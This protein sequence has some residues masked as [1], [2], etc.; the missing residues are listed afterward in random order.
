MARSTESILRTS[1][2]TPYAQSDPPYPGGYYRFN[3]SVCDGMIPPQGGAISVADMRYR[4][5]WGRS[6]FNG[7][8]AMSGQPSGAIYASSFRNSIIFRVWK[9]E[10][11]KNH[12]SAQYTDPRGAEIDY[13]MMSGAG[14]ASWNCLQMSTGMANA[15]ISQG[16]QYIQD[17]GPNGDAWG[18]VRRID[19]ANVKN[20]D[21]QWWDFCMRWGTYYIRVYK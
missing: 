21:W 5:F 11:W 12:R 19:S 14:G 16:F 20:G 18:G 7:Y 4:D 17:M 15:L 13:C 2:I 1:G 6:D 3:R 9:E 8:R 10:W